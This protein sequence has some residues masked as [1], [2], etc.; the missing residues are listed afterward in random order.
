MFLNRFKTVFGL[1]D[2][3][4]REQNESGFF[5]FFS[6]FAR[7]ACNGAPALMQEPC[8]AF[9]DKG[10]HRPTQAAGCL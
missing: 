2:G 1:M 6:L 5:S 4:I 3:D 10:G 7:E 9:L 8:L